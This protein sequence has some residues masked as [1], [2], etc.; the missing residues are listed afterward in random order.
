[1]RE[2]NEKSEKSERRVR[3][4]SEGR[5]REER[6]KIV[7]RERFLI[8]NLYI[9]LFLFIPS[10]LLLHPQFPN[11]HRTSHKLINT[12]YIYIYICSLL[13]HLPPHLIDET[14]N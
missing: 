6:E 5:V 7:R 12:I 8:I 9:T 13:H 4:D 11:V 3:E 14:N 1:M 10:P 2:E